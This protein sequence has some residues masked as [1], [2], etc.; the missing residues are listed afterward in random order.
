MPVDLS[1]SELSWAVSNCDGVHVATLM[2][3]R[4]T[5]WTFSMVGVLEKKSEFV[6]PMVDAAV[7]EQGQILV[8]TPNNIEFLR[9][10][11]E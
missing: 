1:T 5:I 8:A 11:K 3:N 7:T 6:T 9:F 10:G 4:T 2:D